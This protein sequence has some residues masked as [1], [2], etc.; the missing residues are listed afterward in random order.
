MPRSNANPGALRWHHAESLLQ[1]RR[2]AA[3]LYS[4]LASGYNECLLHSGLVAYPHGAFL[5]H[6][7]GRLSF[8]IVLDSERGPANAISARWSFNMNW[9]ISPTHCFNYMRPD[10][11][12]NE[13]YLELERYGRWDWSFW[14]LVKCCLRATH[15]APRRAVLHMDLNILTRPDGLPAE[16]QGPPNPMESRAW[17]S[18]TL[19]SLS[20]TSRILFQG[21][22]HPFSG[23]ASTVK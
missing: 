7:C 23:S 1:P 12:E 15:H 21:W 11:S 3:N 10:L 5:D 9:V 6:D 4:C 2:L 13:R 16:D 8:F 14:T 19:P 17:S 18:R 22:L 20:V